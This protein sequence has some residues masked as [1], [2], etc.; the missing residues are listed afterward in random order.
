VTATPTG[1]AKATD[2]EIE[3]VIIVP[4]SDEPVYH[5]HHLARL[6]PPMT[7]DQYNAL[8]AD[9]R[10][11]G[12]REP[13]VL[14]ED[15]ILDGRYRD[16]ACR[17]LGI[18]VRAKEYDGTDPLGYVVSLNVH[19]RHLE[20]QQR[21][22]IALTVEAEYAKLAKTRQGRRTDRT[23]S[24]GDEKVQPVHASKLAAAAT[25]V[26]PSTVDR[27]KVIRRDAPDLI[28]KLLAG[29]FTIPQARAEIRRRSDRGKGIDQAQPGSVDPTP[30]QA[31]AR[32]A[33]AVV[34]EVMEAFTLLNTRLKK[35]VR[36]WEDLPEDDRGVVAEIV[37]A[38]TQTQRH[39]TKIRRLASD[40][41]PPDDAP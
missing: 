25:G 40:S 4:V 24:S 5:T 10:D 32:Q 13:I 3:P 22:V 28:D 29:S 31:K 21:A 9:I 1:T 2:V 33:E 19:R 12:L 26:S 14:Y 16:Q 37:T 23:S 15:M 36:M 7:A 39:V 6:I 38:A 11:H 27:V 30:Q 41:R 8:V 18:E 17:E 34:H 35:A 20:P